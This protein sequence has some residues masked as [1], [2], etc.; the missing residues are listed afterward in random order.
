MSYSPS[1]VP[2]YYL[3]GRMSDQGDL[4]VLEFLDAQARIRL[5]NRQAKVVIPHEITGSDPIL[6]VT[7]FQASPI[8]KQES[9]D[10][11]DY[12]NSVRFILDNRPII[13]A[14]KSWAQ[15]AGAKAELAVAIRLDLSVM[16]WDGKAFCEVPAEFDALV[17]VINGNSLRHHVINCDEP[18]T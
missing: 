7:R 3:V 9:I 2:L 1:D 18:E 16:F 5:W 14:L 4:H 11:D 10:H 12:S 15:S 17:H 6:Y 8:V 13:I